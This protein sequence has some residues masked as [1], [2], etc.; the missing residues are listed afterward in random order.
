MARYRFD[1]RFAVATSATRAYG[2]IVAPEGWLPAWADA[3]SVERTAAGDAD[4]LGA[5]FVATVRSPFG[6]RL[7]ARIE[8]VAARPPEHAEMA[9]TGG[10]EGRGRWELQD[11]D[12]TTQ[13]RF[14]WDVRA[15]E[16]WMK[17]LSPLARPV[18]EWAHGEVMRH[19][20]EAAAAHL[21]AELLSF[22]S[23]PVR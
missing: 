18:F 11:R 9:A 12:G 14:T 8:T 2:A 19:A 16:P 10:L 5:V 15:T 20:V 4:G 22:R 13:V 3:V 7:S 6:Y 21:D 23:T 17:A 1:T